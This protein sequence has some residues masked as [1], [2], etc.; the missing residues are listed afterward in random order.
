MGKPIIFFA[1]LQ[2]KRVELIVFFFA[3]F[4]PSRLK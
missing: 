1:T 3:F 4:S 2:G